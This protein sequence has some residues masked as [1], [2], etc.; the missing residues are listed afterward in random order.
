MSTLAGF[1]GRQ[2][3]PFLD[4]LTRVSMPQP[5]NSVEWWEEAARRAFRFF[6]DKAE[7]MEWVT[8]SYGSDENRFTASVCWD[9]VKLQEGTNHDRS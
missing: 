3:W 7:F 8:S 6:P 9:I 4:E 5:E 1:C 2:W